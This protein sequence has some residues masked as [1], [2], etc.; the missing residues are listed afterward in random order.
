MSD[1]NYIKARKPR[2]LFSKEEDD[3]LKSL[4]AQFGRK[5]WDF[6]ASLL[7]GRTGRQCRE[8][9][10]NYL[11]PGTCYGQWT[12]DEDILLNLKYQEIGPH[13][14]KMTHFFKGRSANSIKNRW[15]CCVCKMP[16]SSLI[17]KEILMKYASTT[18][19]KKAQRKP[20]HKVT[21]YEDPKAETENEATPLSSEQKSQEFSGFSIWECSYDDID[22]TF[23]SLYLDLFH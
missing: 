23:N 3:K 13:W 4:V 7:P 17:P 12:H 22:A 19:K 21:E 14:S 20:N 15:N 1:T 5:S 9:Y 10:R 8:R 16:Q 6:I 18:R 2:K 11:L